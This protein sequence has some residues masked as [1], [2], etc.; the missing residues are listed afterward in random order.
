MY[1]FIQQAVKMYVSQDISKAVSL[2][3]LFIQ[4]FEAKILCGTTD[5]KINNNCF[6]SSKSASLH[7][8]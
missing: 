6:L 2:T 8:F 1:S 5:F 4:I 3:F 7:D